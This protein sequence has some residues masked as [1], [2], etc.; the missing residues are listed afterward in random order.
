MST[1][2]K[3]RNIALVMGTAA[4]AAGSVVPMPTPYETLTCLEACMNRLLSL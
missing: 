3:G 2:E 4:I 1:L